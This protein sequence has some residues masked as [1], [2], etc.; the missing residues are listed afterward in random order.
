M[1]KGIGYVIFIF[2]LLV[3]FNLLLSLLSHLSLPSYGSFS[4][5]GASGV[6]KLH[7]SLFSKDG[8]G[9]SYVTQG[10]GHTPYSSV[11]PNDWHDGVDIAALYGTPIY[12]PNDGTVF[13]TGNEDLYCFHRAFGKYIAISDPA[14]N[15]ILWYAHLGT[16]DV[17]TG[18]TISKGSELGTVGATGFETGTHLHFSI[19][20]ANGFSMQPREGCGP[21]PTGQDVDPMNYLGTT[22]R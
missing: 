8:S 14:N 20:E 6:V 7:V 11:Y 9:L 3:A 17:K 1:S 19:F 21:E 10:Y 18:Q 12:S 4:P 16:I 5:S 22:Y 15:L 13:A 2:G